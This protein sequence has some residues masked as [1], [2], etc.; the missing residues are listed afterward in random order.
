MIS[1]DSADWGGL[2]HAYGAASDI[3][4]LLRDLADDPA[5]KAG[6]QA[7]PWFSL[8]SALC[9]QGDVY[10][11]SYAA[12]PHLVAICLAADCPVDMGFFLLAASIEV[13][14]ATEHGPG[15]PARLAQ[16][17]QEALGQLHSCAFHQATH[18]W[19]EAIALSIA[20]A[21]AAAKGQIRLAEAIMCLDG[22][23]MNKLIA[24]A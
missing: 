1:L 17:Y 4:R 8:W 7:E 5:P 12:V 9:H 15:V 19:D 6:F 18:E 14:R 20:A 13:A 21:L 11:A 3:P 22:D 24:D 2:D 10:T 23:I 16:P